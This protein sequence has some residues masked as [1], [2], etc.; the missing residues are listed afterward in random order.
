MATGVDRSRQQ[1]IEADRRVHT[2]MLD[3]PYFGA[4][5]NHVWLGAVTRKSSRGFGTLMTLQNV[6]WRP[7][8]RCA[9]AISKALSGSGARTLRRRWR[10]D[11]KGE[12]EEPRLQPDEQPTRVVREAEQGL[13][14]ELARF[15]SNPAPNRQSKR[16]LGRYNHALPN[17]LWTSS[18]VPDS[19]LTK[20]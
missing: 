15:C 4:T 1:F 16:R 2:A 6:S 11:V 5:N 7:L 9:L 14:G 13:I 17:L 8:K 12:S 18:R 10:Y 20:S 19:V 3:Q